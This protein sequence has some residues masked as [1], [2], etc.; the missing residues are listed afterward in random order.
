[1]ESIFVE[2][3][4]LS[5]ETYDVAIDINHANPIDLKCVKVGI[6][7]SANFT[8]TNRGHYEVKYA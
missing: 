3:L 6:L 2:T 1:M 4:T 5:G 8:I 7:T